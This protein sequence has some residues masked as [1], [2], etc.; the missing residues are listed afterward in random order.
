MTW[1][2]SISDECTG[3]KWVNYSDGGGWYMRSRS[4]KCPVHGYSNDEQE[5]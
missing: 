3:C 2:D 4:K 1:T 5:A